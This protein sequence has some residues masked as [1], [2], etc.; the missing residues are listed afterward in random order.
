MTL[1]INFMGDYVY[2]SYDFFGSPHILQSF[3]ISQLNLTPY[4]LP[5]SFSTSKQ[6]CDYVVMGATCEENEALKIFGPNS[7][8]KK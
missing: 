8:R 4:D 2:N 3:N 1:K 6:N 7:I 5:S